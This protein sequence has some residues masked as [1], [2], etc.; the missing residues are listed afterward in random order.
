[1]LPWL[2]FILTSPAFL[3]VFAIVVM[4]VLPKFDPGPTFFSV[5]VFGFAIRYI[6]L[7]LPG[8]VIN[9]L[10]NNVLLSTRF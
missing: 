5:Y 7:P 2:E 6:K 3:P 10:A 9:M 1:M 4:S 8:F